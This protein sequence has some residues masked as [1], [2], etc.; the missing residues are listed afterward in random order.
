M[1]TG[2]P[3]ISATDAAPAPDIG[4]SSTAPVAAAEG[5]AAAATASADSAA[6]H[7]PT[8]VGQR[9]PTSAV[10]C[11]HAL[12]YAPAYG[13]RVTTINVHRHVGTP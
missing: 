3:V 7:V 9:T 13:G 10:C 1:A 4:S 2:A 6:V 5:A 8:P 12:G 11:A